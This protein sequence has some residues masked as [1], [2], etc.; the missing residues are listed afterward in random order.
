[1]VPLWWASSLL[2]AAAF[3]TDSGA[4]RALSKPLAAVPGASVSPGQGFMKWIC[5]VPALL[6]PIYWSRAREGEGQQVGARSPAV[7]FSE[8]HSGYK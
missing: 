3:Q 1:M 6:I 7:P 5:S 2:P 4:A 8:C